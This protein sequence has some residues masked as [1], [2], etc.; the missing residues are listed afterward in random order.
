MEITD[1]KALLP[2]VEEKLKAVYG[3][4]A[5]NIKIQGPLEQKKQYWVVNA[6]IDDE[7]VSR[8]ISMNIRIEDGI[9]TKMEL[10]EERAL[11]RERPRISKKELGKPQEASE[12]PPA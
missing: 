6:E 5:Q 8:S 10:R 3:E 7:K 1:V 12:F 11:S 4:A 9:V 2:V